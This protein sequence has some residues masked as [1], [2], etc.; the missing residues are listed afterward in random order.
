MTV[1]THRIERHAGVEISTGSDGSV[2]QI[3]FDLRTRGYTA[4]DLYTNVVSLAYRAQ[5]Y[6]VDGVSRQTMYITYVLCDQRDAQR[7]HGK[8]HQTTDDRLAMSELIAHCVDKIQPEH[9]SEITQYCRGV[10]ALHPELAA[11]FK[12]MVIGQD[13]KTYPITSGNGRP[14]PSFGILPTAEIRQ[15][16]VQRLVREEFSYELLVQALVTGKAVIRQ[17]GSFAQVIGELIVDPK[18]DL[19]T[20][21]T[22][23]VLIG[24]LPVGQ[25]E[26]GT[27]QLRSRQTAGH[28]VLLDWRHVAALQELAG[29]TAAPRRFDRQPRKCPKSPQYQRVISTETLYHIEIL[30]KLAEAFTSICTEHGADPQRFGLEAHASAIRAVEYANTRETY[31]KAQDRLVDLYAS[32]EAAFALKLEDLLFTPLPAEPGEQDTPLG[33]YDVTNLTEPLVEAVKASWPEAD[34]TKHRA[35][36]QALISKLRRFVARCTS[37]AAQEPIIRRFMAENYDRYLEV[38]SNN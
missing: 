12:G 24:R 10:S 23:G 37:R 14:S 13:G 16:D 36:I 17:N 19:V 11:L 33:F 34:E 1:E 26:G 8:P 35:L 27:F 6:E 30:P 7:V 22:G 32:S 15:I 25:I 9:A 2:Q 21:C 20:H 4:M 38:P 31:H 18:T 29:E 28:M 3:I 5:P